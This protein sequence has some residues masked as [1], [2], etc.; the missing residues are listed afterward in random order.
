MI[1]AYA[2]SLSVNKVGLNAKHSD[3]R[4]TTQPINQEQVGLNAKH[5]H[6]QDATIPFKL[7][8]RLPC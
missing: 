5:W 3:S 8:F 6:A 7:T 1:P 2:S 4:D